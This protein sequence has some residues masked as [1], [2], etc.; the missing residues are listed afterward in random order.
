MKKSTLKKG[1]KLNGIGL[2]TGKT[3]AVSVI[4]SRTG[5][6]QFLREGVLI[7]AIYSN[8]VSTNFAVTL[9]KD[10]KT[11]STVEHLLSALHMLGIDSAVV[12]VDGPEIPILDGSA[13][14]F[15]DAL[16]KVGTEKIDKPR[17]YFNVKAPIEISIEDKYLLFL[18]SN[19]FEVNYTIS[20]NHP[21]L[22][23][24]SE[25][26]K[27]DKDTYIN[28]ISSART[29]TFLNVV[30]KLKADGLIK[31]GSFDNAIVLDENGVVNGDLRMENECLRHK[32]LDLIGDIY[33]LGMPI[34]ARIIAYKAGHT[35]D[36]KAVKTL[37]FYNNVKR[38]HV[39]AGAGLSYLYNYLQK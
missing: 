8:V 6:I 22:D 23:K 33:L 12:E 15:V 4:P 38:E 36:I 3:I 18:P 28:G 34:K 24:R 1:I 17:N 5:K 35:L 20:F 39:P 19:K 10:G 30:N 7:D 11:I 16:L 26:L 32:I 21:L 2:H 27:I 14:P 29:F 13:K 25:D 37:K 31:G 9:G